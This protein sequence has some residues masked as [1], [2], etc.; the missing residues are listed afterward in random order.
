MTREPYRTRFPVVLTLIPLVI[1]A[2]TAAL[3]WG[4]PARLEFFTAATHVLALGAV[5]M[6]L[7]GRFFRLATHVEHGARG[8]PAVVNIVAMLAATGLGLFYSFRALALGSGGSPG[9]AMTAGALASGVASFAVQALFG[10]PGSRDD[11]DGPA[12]V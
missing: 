2:A 10:T 11:E 8:L 5:G 6:A 3:L 12:P 7:S 4:E 9:L 1:G